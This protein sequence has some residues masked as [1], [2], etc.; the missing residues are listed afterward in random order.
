MPTILDVSTKEKPQWC[1][2]C[3]D[4]GIQMALKNA[5]VELNLEPQ[6]TVVVSG[7][8]CSGKIPHYVNTYGYESIH[9]RSLP[10]ASAIKLANHDLTVIAA[11]GDGDGYEIGAQHF[12]HLM[13]RNY[14]ITYL[15]H[16]NQIYGLTTGQAS[17]TSMKGMKSTSTPFGVIETPFMPIA[18]AIILGAT[19]VARGFAGDIKHLTQLIKNGIQHKGTALIDIFQPCVTYN[20][21]NTYQFFQQ[22]IYKLEEAGHDQTNKEM[23]LKKAYEDVVTN[24]EKIPIGVF[25]REERPTYEQQLPA[26]SGKPLVEQDISNVDITKSFEEFE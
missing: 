22:K 16:N 23:A 3:G 25:F 20:K 18:T 7:I 13:R 14:D 4:F 12:V 2:A 11:G 17:P 10:V 24:Y 26:L 9:G 21:I 19:Y 8:G 15:V 5:M 1:P 6:N